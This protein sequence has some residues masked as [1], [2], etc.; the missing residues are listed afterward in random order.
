MGQFVQQVRTYQAQ[1]DAALQTAIQNDLNAFSADEHW[2]IKEVKEVSFRLYDSRAIVVFEKETNKH[3]RIYSASLLS[4]Q[5][6]VPPVGSS[7]GSI[8]AITRPSPG[9]KLG[10]F[11]AY[12]R[13]EFTKIIT[14]VLYNAT[15]NILRASD[16]AVLGGVAVNYEPDAPYDTE[17]PLITPE[18][19]IPLLGGRLKRARPLHAEQ[20]FRWEPGLFKLDATDTLFVLARTYSYLP[21]TVPDVYEGRGFAIVFYYKLDA[22]DNPI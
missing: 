7:P 21:E 11:A 19:T 6:I 1:T 3:P 12:T 14:P 4:N 18:G 5:L 16:N 15:W 22:N 17:T 9:E 10:I 20:I 8:F 2:Y 13:L